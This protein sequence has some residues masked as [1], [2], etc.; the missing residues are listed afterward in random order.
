MNANTCADT[1]DLEILY[2]DYYENFKDYSNNTSSHWKR[3]GELQRVKKIGTVYKLI[4]S[5]FGDFSER[6]L[7][8]LLVDVPTKVYLFNLNKSCS[9]KILEGT[10]WVAN[11]QKRRFSYDLSRMAL[12]LDL[13]SK[14][15]LDLKNKTFC[16]IGD[17]Y[18][19][20]GCLIK[21]IYPNSKIIYVNLGRT[22][23]FDFYYSKKCFP[24]LKHSL[25]R[26]NQYNLSTD[27]NYIE[28]EYFKK[29]FFTSDIFINIASMQE[30]NYEEISSYFNAI[31]NQGIDSWFY[32]CNRVSK[33]LPDGSVINFSEYG[34]D[35]NDEIIIDEL[36]PWQQSFPI[37]WPPFSKKFD[38]PI[39]HRLIK[40]KNELR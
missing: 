38:G 23:F 36:C 39:K 8:R 16:V 33:T 34:W 13:L 27:F 30:M 17:G 29:I 14:K 40:L 35:D 4:G 22:L 19:S 9:Q 11:K 25:I 24:E 32:C 20:L 5:G 6:S 18:G 10:H 1:D 7:L 31:R 3:Y 21:K 2:F 12:T 26:S 37:N 28:A 15:I